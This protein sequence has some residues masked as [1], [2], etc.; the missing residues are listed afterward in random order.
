MPR[1]AFQTFG[2]SYSVGATAVPHY[3][4]GKARTTGPPAMQQQTPSKSPRGFTLIELLTVIAIIAVLA[5]LLFPIAGTVREQARATDCLSKLHQLWVSA[6]VYR[7]GL[8]GHPPDLLGYAELAG[9]GGL[10]T[11]T[12]Y[13]GGAG[14]SPTD[15]VN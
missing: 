3:P 8:C 5:A 14:S 9:S 11:G 7:Q 2:Q 4:T 6:N 12:Y 10:S 13:V 15:V 1:R